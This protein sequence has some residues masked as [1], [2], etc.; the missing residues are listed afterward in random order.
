MISEDRLHLMIQLADYKQENQNGSLSIVKFDKKDYL[1]FALAKNLVITTI[2][3]GIFLGVFAVL[4]I[5]F[6]LANLQDDRFG[7]L[8]AV[9]LILYLMILGVYS[10]IVYMIKKIQY[11]RAEDEVRG[12][13]RYME[14]LTQM[15]KQEQMR[16]NNPF[17]GNS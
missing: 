11:I 4:H 8:L 7:S 12:Y 3:Y 10:L 16:K 13:R 1:A 6:I 2:L 14:S 9:V 17:G 15:Y 5:E